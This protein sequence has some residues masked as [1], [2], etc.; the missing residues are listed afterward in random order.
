MTR[1]PYKRKRVRGV[2]LEDL[3]HR[4]ASGPCRIPRDFVRFGTDYCVEVQESH[5]AIAEV[6]NMLHQPLIVTARDVFI[7]SVARRDLLEPVPQLGVTLECREYDVVSVSVL[8]VLPGVVSEVN[9][10]G[11]Q[12]RGHV[13]HY[14][15]PAARGS[16]Q[17]LY[18]LLAPVAV[19]RVIGVAL[20]GSRRRI[21]LPLKGFRLWLNPPAR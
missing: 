9:R 2:R 12:S 14:I 1:G 15:R 11:N 6:S 5:L 7:S 8:G 17:P 16:K 4:R 3:I 18:W 10:V 19:S 21:N 20:G 13:L